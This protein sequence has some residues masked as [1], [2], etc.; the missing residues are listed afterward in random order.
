MPEI[1][2]KN[3]VEQ[4]R[5]EIHQSDI[6]DR[7]VIH[8]ADVVQV[9]DIADILANHILE[10][11]AQFNVTREI[12]KTNAG[13]IEK[14][15]PLAALVPSLELMIEEKRAYTLLA[16]KIVKYIGVAGATV[17]LIYGALKLY[18]DFFRHK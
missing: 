18:S 1:N 5:T 3:V 11:Q 2:S 6:D 10:N 4:S 9:Q 12:G 16:S 14:L 13:N 17:G 7:Q 15:M 8:S